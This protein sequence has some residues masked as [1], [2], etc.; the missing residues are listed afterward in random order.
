MKKQGGQDVVEFA[1]VF[2]L[3]MMF[4]F[5]IIYF[6]LLCSQYVS[7]NNWVRSAAR[8]AAVSLP[9]NGNYD[10]LAKYYGDKFEAEQGDFGL[11]KMKSFQIEQI[12]SNDKS[13]PEPGE[14]RYEV[15]VTLKLQEKPEAGGVIYMVTHLINKSIFNEEPTFV[16]TMYDENYEQK[17]S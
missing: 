12:K 15:R 6:G 9:Q 4:I 13:N 3:F 11:Y 7:C 14:E 2:F 5:G 16:Y 1:L 10:D 8:E 17:K